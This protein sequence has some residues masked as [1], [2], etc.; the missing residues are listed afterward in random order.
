MVNVLTIDLEEWF[1]VS[2]FEHVIRR[3][4]WG[5]MESRVRPATGRILDLLDRHQAKATF[6]VLGWVAEQYPALVREIAD[7]G[8]EIGSHSHWHRLVYEM[9]PSEFR[10]DVRQSRDVLADVTGKPVRA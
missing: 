4:D 8:H 2:N 10:D 3:E 5:E 7:R 1:C 9:S 6:F